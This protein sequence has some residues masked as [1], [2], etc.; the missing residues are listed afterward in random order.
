MDKRGITVT[1]PGIAPSIGTDGHQLCLLP[2]HVAHEEI[3]RVRSE[4]KRLHDI[5]GD[6]IGP[7]DKSPVGANPADVA[8]GGSPIC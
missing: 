2:Q 7:E 6:V 5:A 3:E 8:F 1:V 4:G